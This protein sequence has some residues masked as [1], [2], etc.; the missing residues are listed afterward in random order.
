MAVVSTK[1]SIDDRSVSGKY[2]DTF[3]YSRSFL[4]LL[5]SP[6]TSMV[7]IARAP[8][9]QFGDAHPDDSSVY[10]MEFDCKPRGDSMLVY[11]VTV[12]YYTPTR[13]KEVDP[14]QLPADVWAG[15]SSVTAAPCW[16]DAEGKPITNSAGVAFP[17]LTKDEAEFSVTLTRC[18]EDLSFL[19]IIVGVSNRLNSDE[20]LGCPKHTWKCQG[21]RFSKKRENQAGTT[22]EYWE[23]VFEFAY[24]KDTW[25]LKPLD[26]GYS[27]LVDDTSAPPA[28]KKLSAI[29]GGDKKPIKEPASLDNGV[30]VANG[31]EGFPKVINGGKGANPYE[32]TSFAQFGTIS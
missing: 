30:A 26:I 10:A 7:D 32:E 29:L 15:G 5:D 18:Y 3:T 6:D 28:G 23:V 19:A 25:F 16:Q 9:V 21:A 17:D 20:F 12:K 31:T 13:E 22:V 2:R 8:N 27:E 1:E 11:V 14:A 24:R 4:V